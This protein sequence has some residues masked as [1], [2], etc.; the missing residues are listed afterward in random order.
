ML[1]TRVRRGVLSFSLVVTLV[2]WTPA[3]AVTHVRAGSTAPGIPSG[4][5][6]IDVLAP[7]D[8]GPVPVTVGVPVPARDAGGP[9]RVR[10]PD[11]STLATQVRERV[12]QGPDGLVWLLVDFVAPPG[13]AEY[14]LERGGSPAPPSP[15]AV[16]EDPGGGVTI[17]TGTARWEIPATTELLARV[18]ASDGRGVIGGAGFGPSKPAE[19][20]VRERGPVRAQ[21]EVRARRAVA[22]LDLVA[23]LDF[24]AG[25]P[26]AR[27]RIT[28]TNHRRCVLERDAPPEADNGPFETEANQPSCNGLESANR[29]VIT[30]LSWGVD[31]ADPTGG[32][33][34]VLA[35][36]ADDDAE[37]SLTSGDVRV[38]VRWFRELYPQALRRVDD[39]LEVGL[40]PREAAVDH[41]L[42]AG[43]QKTHELVVSIDPETSAPF[44]VYAAPDVAWLATTE[45]FGPLVGRTTAPGPAAAYERY[46]EDQLDDAAYD[47]DECNNDLD[48]CA[49]SVFDARQRFGYFGWRNFGDIPTD[50]EDPRSPYN[51]KYD[52]NLGFLIQAIR[53]DDPRWWELAHSANVHYADIDI[54]HSRVRGVD[55]KRAW[56]EG[57]TWGHSYH[58]ERGI[59][60]PH[61]NYANPNPDTYWGAAGLAAWSL[62][63]GDPVVEDAA[64][65]LADNTA[66]RMRNSAD[67]RCDR[68]VYG[69]G[70][71]EGYAIL[72]ANSRAV[73]N[74]TRILVAGW[75]ITGERGYLETAGL[76]ADWVGC[77]AGAIVPCASWKEALLARAL[78][79]EVA[80]A[81]QAG[82]PVPEAGADS[83][84][85]L[86]AALRDRLETRD[87]RAWL[88]DCERF[89]EINAWELLVAD[90]FAYS[91]RFSGDASWLEQAD[92]VFTTGAEDPYYRGDTSQY[93]TSK[94]LVNVVDDGL[95]YLAA[96]YSS[97]T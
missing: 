37:G 67:T 10:G 13:R 36:N 66:W 83:V 52:A 76:A 46:L 57:G 38:D 97:E 69:G 51:L 34:T 61:R 7:T 65:E 93:H 44:P 70:S 81:D 55:A 82:L 54:L 59:A 85:T 14:T 68:R 95:V 75:R 20:T 42:R 96:R 23:R 72:E 30:D 47:T 6:P 27:V 56:W 63:T 84:V 19:L 29:V 2:P 78:A 1:W 73:A 26:F 40:W 12:R 71:G 62:V 87:D 86:A 9:W 94:E 48:E 60:N 88:V 22:G 58:D 16:T 41:V 5:I 39:R 92:L 25:L 17:D 31:V 79:E 50:F 45:A 11:G 49:R 3:R 8:S 53:G 35:A 18:A 74:A 64:I 77:E 89:A 4:G 91:A 32:P 33:T 21:V 28:L 80:V 15:V 90:V 43:E 24:T